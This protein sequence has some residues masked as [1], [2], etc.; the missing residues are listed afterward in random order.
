MPRIVRNTL[1]NYIPTDFATEQTIN[2]LRIFELNNKPIRNGEIIY[3]CEREIRVKDN[4]ALQ[5]A[6]QKSEELNLPLKIIHPKINYDYQ[7]KQE[8]IDNQIEQVKTQFRNIGL[9][10]EI[11]EK[12]PQEII[13]NINPAILI[14]DFNP[15]L[16]RDYLKKAD[17]K[18]FEIDGHNIVPARFISDKQEYSA[19][20]I[21]RKIYYNVYPF[22]TEFVNLTSDKIEADLVLEDFIKNKLQ[23]YSENKNNPSLNVTSGLSKYLNLGFIASQRVALEILKSGVSDINKETFL[24]ELI[25][26]KE[27][28]DNFCLYSKSFKDFSDIPNWAKISFDNHKYDIRPYIYSLEMLEKAKTHDKLWNAT[29][30]QLIKE[31]TIHGYLR[32]YWAKKI[33]EW[34]STADEALKVAIYL[35][36]KYA[37][38]APSA[39]GY[40]GILWAIGGL[41]DRAFADYPV[42]GKI[43]RMT[44]DSMKRKYDLSNYIKKYTKI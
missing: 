29:Q 35:N 38:D 2:P 16:K 7:Q 14:I 21:R 33:L 32:M 6:F 37:Y 5:F 25:I 10:F 43:R 26:R 39:N 1:L 44:Y 20:T 41:H 36:D 3:L 42:T 18:I 40:V 30:T 24:E 13:K 4:F 27:L 28:T 8:F 22:L 19:S 31:G 17:F 15:I 9:D 34:M 11:I 12:T 23:Y